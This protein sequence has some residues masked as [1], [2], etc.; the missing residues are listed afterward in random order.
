M[1]I[2]CATVADCWPGNRDRFKSLCVADLSES[3]YATVTRLALE[4]LAQKSR[5][6]QAMTSPG[7]VLDYL[8]LALADRKHEVFGCVFLDNR[9]RVISTEEMFTGSIAS[10]SVSP[11]V[12]V[13]RALELNAAAVV[14]FHNHPSGDPKPSA[15]DKAMTAKL[16]RALDLVDVRVIDHFVVGKE[17]AVSFA[18]SGLLQSTVGVKS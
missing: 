1:F 18:E 4:V 3:E 12:V 7:V 11:R 13:Q 9:H 6:G 8:R 5:P 14:L 2:D 15:N 17:G 10:A 16:Q